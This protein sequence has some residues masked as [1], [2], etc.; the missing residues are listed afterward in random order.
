MLSCNLRKWW[1]LLL[2]VCKCVV[3]LGWPVSACSPL[4]LVCVCVC[5]YQIAY[6]NL[7]GEF[8]NTYETVMTKQ[9]AH[10]RTE[11]CRPASAEV[12]ATVAQAR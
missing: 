9:Y 3:T 6:Y 4:S 11:A 2:L 8:Q 12:S 7:Y 10:G 5:S 1:F